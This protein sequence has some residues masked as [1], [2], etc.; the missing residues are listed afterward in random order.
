LIRPGEHEFAD[1]LLLGFG[2]VLPGRPLGGD[3]LRSR[4]RSPT[5]FPI[6][7]IV[8][9]TA[10]FPR[11]VSGSASSSL[12]LLGTTRRSIALRP[13]CSP[14]RIAARCLRGFGGFV[15]SADAPT[16]SGWSD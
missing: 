13:A 9:L 7:T 1:P 14:D 6:V 8:T 2:Q 12:L 4:T 10:A 15:T 11:N 3:E 5:S 16:A